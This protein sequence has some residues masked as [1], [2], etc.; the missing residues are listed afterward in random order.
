H[1]AL[2]GRVRTS[3]QRGHGYPAHDPHALRAVIVKGPLARVRGDAGHLA[4]R[5]LTG[6]GVRCGL[7][8]AEYL[9]V[10]S[11]GRVHLLGRLPRRRAE[12]RRSWE[13]AAVGSGEAVCCVVRGDETGN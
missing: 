6:F 12:G 5:L 2:T 1:H 7:H 4:I 8:G 13:G 11:D 3:V 10:L 9:S